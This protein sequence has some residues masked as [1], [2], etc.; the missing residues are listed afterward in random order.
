[1]PGSTTERRY[2]RVKTPKGCVVAWQGPSQRHVSRVKTM[3]LGG[4]FI[5][6]N[7]PPQVGST[8]QLLFDASSGEVRA[9]AVVRSVVAGQ[10]MGIEIISM[11]PEH[12]ARLARWL[13][14]LPADA[15]PSDQKDSSR[16]RRFERI[17]LPKGMWVAWYGGGEQQ[18]SRVGTLGMAG[19]FICEP[20]PPLVGT[21]V[22]LAFEVP[23]GNVIAEAVVRSVEPGKG[24]G[25]EFTKVAPTDSVLLQ[26]LLKRLLRV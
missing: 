15:G 6:T 12:R 23:G 20:N 4:L 10:G 21:S 1:M 13:Q 3:G 24:M 25:V 18:T 7:D 14:H 2:A 5:S 11:Q 16:K 9:R 19:V 22:R 26:R 8:I 17:A